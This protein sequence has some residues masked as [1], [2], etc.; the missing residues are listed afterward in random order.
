MYIYIYLFHARYL[1]NDIFRYVTSEIS[2]DIT[3][4]YLMAVYHKVLSHGC[5]AQAHYQSIYSNRRGE[6]G[7][8]PLVSFSNFTPVSY[9][10]TTLVK[11]SSVE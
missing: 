8:E 4:C 11:I 7:G 5:I 9:Q 2:Q 6:G 1:H 3:T 10:K